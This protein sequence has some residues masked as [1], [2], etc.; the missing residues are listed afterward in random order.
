MGEIYMERISSYFNLNK[1]Q[2]ELD[3]VDVYTNADIPLF[4]DPYFISR[5]NDEW[6]KKASD[7]IRDFFQKIIENINDKLDNNIIRV[8]K[9]ADST[10]YILFINLWPLY[11]VAIV[12]IICSILLPYSIDSS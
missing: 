2:L 9:V 7:E 5:N 1:G 10:L 11:I 12:L 8:S 4:V 3:F 6:S